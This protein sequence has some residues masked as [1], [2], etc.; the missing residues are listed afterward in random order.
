MPQF[1]PYTLPMLN[2]LTLYNIYL[3]K[4]LKSAPFPILQPVGFLLKIILLIAHICKPPFYIHIHTHFHTQ[5]NISFTHA[6]AHIHMLCHTHF[7]T[8]FNKEVSIGNSKALLGSF[9]VQ[10]YITVDILGL[11]STVLRD[12]RSLQLAGACHFQTNRNYKRSD[13]YSGGYSGNILHYTPENE[14][15]HRMT[16]GDY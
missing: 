16:N 3:V 11:T 13:T 12:G 14:I 8:Q 5:F 4:W 9:F 2:Q 6:F 15:M 7:H 1:A 10:W